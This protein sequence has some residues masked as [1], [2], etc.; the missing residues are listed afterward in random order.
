LQTS[1]RTP[2]HFPARIC[3]DYP[4]APLP[5]ASDHLFGERERERHRE[6]ER[7]G[8]R[9]RETER[10][11]ERQRDRETERE[12]ERD[13]QRHTVGE[14][15]EM[16]RVQGRQK[17]TFISD[18]DGEGRQVFVEGPRGHTIPILKIGEAIRVGDVIAEEHGL[19]EVR[20]GVKGVTT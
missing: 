19:R 10:E 12:R 3:C 6:S 9:E 4:A 1:K 11:T 17:F 18:E 8:N 7:Q 15:R 5:C 13:R 14:R 16:E 20:V 2:S